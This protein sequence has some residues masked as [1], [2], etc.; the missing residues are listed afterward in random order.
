VRDA[1]WPR[2]RPQ[3]FRRRTVETFANFGVRELGEETQ[4]LAASLGREGYDLRKRIAVVVALKSFGSPV[5][6]LHDLLS[7]S[8]FALVIG[9][10]SHGIW[11]SGQLATDHLHEVPL[12][13][14]EVGEVIERAPG[15]RRVVFA[16]RER[17]TYLLLRETLEG[18]KQPRA[19]FVE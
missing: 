8:N 11:V 6:D 1:R 18:R 10:Q 4:R 13:Q 5:H 7:S 17:S 15:D 16:L 2:G 12:N 14:R 3:W 19:T 9:E